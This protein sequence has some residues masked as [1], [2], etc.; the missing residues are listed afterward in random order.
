MGLPGGEADAEEEEGGAG[1]GEE[2]GVAGGVAFEGVSGGHR[3]SLP[4]GVGCL[5]VRWGVDIFKMRANPNRG[6]LCIVVV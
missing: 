1:E 6:C 3:C 2:D 4:L 5:M